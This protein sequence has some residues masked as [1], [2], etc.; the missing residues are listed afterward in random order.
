[1]LT[2]IT[3]SAPVT[4]SQPFQEV[5]LKPAAGVA[6]SVK[7]A[8]SLAVAW[9]VPAAQSMGSVRGV[10]A[11]GSMVLA[12]TAPP[13]VSVTVTVCCTRAKFAVTDF[14]APT[15]ITQSAPVTLSQPLH[16]AKLNP[17]AATAVSV[18][19]APSATLASQF[20]APAAQT[21]GTLCATV[22]PASTTLAVTA[23]LP[24]RV[25][26]RILGTGAGDATA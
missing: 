22:N 2:I 5:K 1:V 3:Q 15:S 23:P 25:T 14:A 13:P 18:T 21:T 6:L 24:E 19:C 7:R 11:P 9:Q 20:A 26:V 17:A 16:E 12:V 8:P 10:A 4:L